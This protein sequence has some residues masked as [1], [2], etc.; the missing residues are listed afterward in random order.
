MSNQT[1]NQVISKSYMS[2]LIIKCGLLFTAGPVLTG[3]VLYL[4]SHQPLGPSYQESFAR[5]SQLKQEMLV[6]SI[7]IYLVLTTIITAGVV[8]IT[9]LYSHRVVGPLVG[10]RR[11]IKRINEGDFTTPAVLREKDV[12]KPM[13]EALNTMEESYRRRINELHGTVKAIKATLDA[14]GDIKNDELQEKVSTLR[15]IVNEL[16]L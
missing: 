11:V 12:I 9:I 2:G 13:A 3:L 15:T 7:V 5:L 16:K 1:G 4:S 6:K 10:L 8:C 14:P